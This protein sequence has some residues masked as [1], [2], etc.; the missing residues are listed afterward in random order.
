MALTQTIITNIHNNWLLYYL[1]P[2][3]VC[4]IHYIFKF[5]LM[6]SEDREKLKKYIEFQEDSTI[7]GQSQS[8][9]HDYMP[10]NRSQYHNYIPSLT[11]GYIIGR[12][13]I[14]YIPATN[15][16]TMLAYALPFMVSNIANWFETILD[17]PLV[18]YKPAN[19]VDNKDN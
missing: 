2:A 18:K 4:T 9:N 17:I 3:V 15:I 19:T 6:F 11:V 12:L 7:Q 8:K 10:Y 13:F 16:F 14:S 1:I 5:F